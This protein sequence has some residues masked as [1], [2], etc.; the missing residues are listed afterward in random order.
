VV[1][2]LLE[3]ET[4]TLRYRCR[5]GAVTVEHRIRHYLVFNAREMHDKT[6]SDRPE[7]AYL[8]NQLHQLDLGGLSGKVTIRALGAGASRWERFETGEHERPSQARSPDSGQHICAVEFSIPREC[9]LSHE[10][11]HDMRT[12]LLGAL[13]GCTHMG[14]DVPIHGT[15]CW[16]P[17]G[18][19]DWLFGNREQA[20]RLIGLPY[21]ARNADATGEGVN[22]VVVDQG[23]DK[24]Q[25]LNFGGGWSAPGGQRPGATKGGHGAML[26]R[27]I[28]N[29]APQATIFDVPLISGTIS[30]SRAFLSDAHGAYATMLEDIEMLRHSERWSGPWVFLNAWAVFDR[31]TEWPHG[32][33][34]SGAQHA[35]NDVIG[36]VVD[37][38]FDVV[39]CAGNCGQ[40]CPM[41]RCG[42]H[43]RGPG[44]SI[45]GANSHPRVLTVGA[46]RVDGIWLGYSSQGP[47]QADL[48]GSYERKFAL[49]KPDV[50]APSQFGAWGDAHTANTGTSAASAI[51]AGA[52][53]ALRSKWPNA[54]TADELKQL[55]LTTARQPEGEGW[56][57]RLGHGIIDLA[58]AYAAAYKEAAGSAAKKAAGSTAAHVV[59][60]GHNTRQSQNPRSTSPPKT[61]SAS[62]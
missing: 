62:G 41:Q 2:A 11:V 31:G 37:R 54:F 17:T 46:V 26:V 58:A 60:A 21:L 35:L 39:F 6:G 56:N 18:P 52:V 33:H 50:C 49:Q 23:V 36:K 38:G 30:N 27:N 19:A 43:D 34:S 51:A 45:L 61:P 44:N 25:I 1:S 4:I 12:K 57:G 14:A 8:Q 42:P 15:S 7:Q 29:I 3:V 55:L 48:A 10:Q 32:D 13:P 20:D 9:E 24:D 28:L 40:F 47:G 22:V 16:S 5:R 53:A 59:T